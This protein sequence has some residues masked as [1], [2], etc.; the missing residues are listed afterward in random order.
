MNP[1]GYLFCFNCNQPLLEA[2]KNRTKAEGILNLIVSDEK[3]KRQFA[4]LL[5]KTNQ[6]KHTA[7]AAT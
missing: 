3:L 5:E 4:A 1:T 6:R 2:S 7:P